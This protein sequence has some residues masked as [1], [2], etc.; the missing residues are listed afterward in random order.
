MMAQQSMWTTEREN[1][2]SCAQKR[3]GYR[4]C[5]PDMFSLNTHTHIYLYLSVYFGQHEHWIWTFNTQHK[6]FG[7]RPH[8]NG[9]III[10]AIICI[11]YD[12]IV[13]SSARAN[14]W[15]DFII[16]HYFHGRNNA[17]D[18]YSH[19]GVGDNRICT[20][21]NIRYILYEHLILVI[22]IIYFY[23]IELNAWIVSVRVV[24][25]SIFTIELNE[26][27]KCCVTIEIAPSGFEAK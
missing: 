24:A 17:D 20:V 23:D 13:D 11:F 2:G 14:E 1:E 3:G 12:D 27:I 21:F 6:T 5:L 9:N 22:I 16:I 7:C 26:V 25:T 19:C 10:M 18:T 4:I 8:I 15:T